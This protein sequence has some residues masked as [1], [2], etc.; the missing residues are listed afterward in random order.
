MPSLELSVSS[1]EGLCRGWVSMVVITGPVGCEALD[2]IVIV[3]LVSFADKSDIWSTRDTGN[4]PLLD[5]CQ[6]NIFRG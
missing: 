5:V 6:Y 3:T 1:S 4:V 2:A